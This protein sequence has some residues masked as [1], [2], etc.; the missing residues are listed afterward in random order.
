MSKLALLGGTPVAATFNK[1]LF[2]WPI[3]TDEMIKAQEQVLR[4]GN[5]SGTDISKRFEEAFAAWQKRKYALSHNNGTSA[6]TAAMYG[7]GVGAG[8]EVIC[9]SVTYWAS[10]LGAHQLGATVVFCDIEEDTLQMSPE[11]FEAHITPRTKLVVVVHYMACP[12]DMDRIM[13][14]A[15]KHGIKVLEDVSH[16]QGGHYKGQ[17][18][19]TFGDAAAMS[20]MAG[21]S[22]AIGEGGML[23]T[24]DYEVYR[25]AV[26]YGHYDRISS[27]YSA[28]E[29]KATNI[30]P[31]GGVKNRMHQCS[32]AVGLVQ[33]SKYEREIAEI[34]KAMKYYWNGLKDID[35]I[36]II[37]PKEEGS[38]K[39]GWYAS[40]C[41]YKPEAFG[42]ISNSLF[43]R[44]LNAEVQ[45]GYGS[46][47][48]FPLHL[49]SL[50]SDIDIYGYGKPTG[51]FFRGDAPSSRELTGE[52]PV[53]EIINSRL[54]ADPWFKHYDTET[55]DKYIEAVHKVADNYK[56]LFQVED[57][58]SKVGGVAL[59]HRK[60]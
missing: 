55:I 47:C 17:M 15:R 5:M 41:H 39:S 59:T 57:Q 21:K 40:R 36:S 2:Q 56:D 3:V 34:D 14:I 38:D 19:G 4:D 22:F 1:P 53:A 46:G 52:L 33:L 37:Y 54:L 32:S 45:G 6:L 42:G 13:A 11:S 16:S 60:N 43:A 18:L 28:D 7:L 8:D 29:Y 9:T 44:A 20:L 30:L 31:F 24:D 26:R 27:V 35:G 49:S 10:C 48:N 23:V 58:S 12:C 51:R 50:F 25:R